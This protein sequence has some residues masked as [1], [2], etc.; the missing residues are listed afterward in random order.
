M[1]KINYPL[2]VS[3]FDGTLVKEDG[4]IDEINKKAI[5]KYIAAGGKFAI[6]TGRMPA[7]ILSRAKELGLKGMVSCCQGSIIMDIE[8]GEV[9]LQGRIPLDT[10]IKIC[11]KMED[12]G[13]HIHVYDLWE[14]YSNM[15]DDALKLYEKAV[16][17]KAN[18]IA[19][20]PISQFVKEKGL[21]SYKVLA[22]VRAEDNERIMNTL[23]KEDFAG[24]ELTKSADYLVEVIN[25]TYSKGTA[26]EFL[27]NY[28]DIP[29]EKTIAIGD[30][31]N[32]LPMIEKAGVGIAVKNADKRLKKKADY[33]CER[34]NEE[35]AIG[36]II[37]KFGFFKED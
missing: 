2:I 19:D 7:G 10:T 32:D 35:G 28:Y 22:M 23:A 37:E 24:C 8:S 21:C 6:S 9:I 14:Y 36:E 26:V 27:A 11:Q 25:N 4:S 3:D 33:I 12:N 16:K 34:T 30:Q 31:L 29:L 1:Q 15:N 20:M 5:A 17:S 13:L 18:I